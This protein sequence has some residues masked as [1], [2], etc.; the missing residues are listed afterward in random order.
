MAK[1]LKT[2]RLIID[3]LFQNI[4]EIIDEFKNSEKFDLCVGIVNYRDH[5]PQEE[6]TYVAQILQF[7]NELDDINSFFENTSTS[8]GGDFPEAVCCA[9]ND[10]LTTLDWRDDAMKVVILFGDAPPHGI[11]NINILIGDLQLRY[12]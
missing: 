12:R 9:L 8:G 10:C 4:N 2:R 5:A 1:I 7:T 3:K 6:L 11:G